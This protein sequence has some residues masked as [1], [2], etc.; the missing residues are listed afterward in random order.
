MSL[1]SEQVAPASSPWLQE[2]EPNIVL[3]QDD[4]VLSEPEHWTLPRNILPT[5]CPKQAP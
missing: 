5:P 4:R 2:G 1:L 3:V